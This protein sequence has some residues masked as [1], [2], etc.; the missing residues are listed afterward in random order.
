MVINSNG[1]G[2][3]VRALL[4]TGCSKSIILKKFKERE[5]RT[6]LP[7]EKK[8]V[9]T[10][11]GGQF[12][13]KSAASV[14]FRLVEFENNNEITIEHEFQV[15]EHHDHKQTKYDMIIGS[16]LLW[17]MGVDISYSR[18]RV[19]WL[20][21]FIPLKEL[22]TLADPEMCEMLYSIH[23][24]SPLIKKMEERTDRIFDADY[25]AV[26]IPAMVNELD[27]SESSKRKLQ[28][29]LEKFPKLF[30]GGLGCLTNQKPASI[31][32]KE[33]SKPYA[34]RYYNLPKAYHAPAKK[35]VE[36]MVKIGVLKEL[37]WNDDSP[38]KAQTLA[39]PKKTKDIR[40]VTDFRKMNACIERHPF[41]LPRI[42]DQLQQLENFA[43]AT[44]LDLSQGFYTIP[45]DEESQKLCTTILPWGNYAYQRMP[46]G[47]A[48]APDMFQSII[49]ELLRHLDYVVCYIDDILILQRTY[50]TES[51]HLH[52]IETVLNLRKRR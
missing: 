8:T 17:N 4:D 46:M 51:D 44:A 22:N 36:R 13:S 23:T 25:S 5:R 52:K 26:D 32:L 47:V 35:E 28:T 27:I 37:P 3:M 2:Q 34:G 31:K 7:D 41:P 15:D 24:D 6:E 49:M 19:E 29:I 40:I 43:S 9:Y 20:D 45:L 50:E 30:D 21:D 18:E 12:V 39:V 38:W 48:C 10:T 11:Y 1:K 42:I 16:D 14:G 33:G